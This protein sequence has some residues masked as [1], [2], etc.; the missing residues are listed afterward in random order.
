MTDEELGI[1]IRKIRNLK[2][3]SQE[4]L[5]T[6]LNMSQKNY[7]R[8]ESGQTS[9]TLKI[10]NQICNIFGIEID[11]LFK[12]SES[13]IFNTITHDQQGGEFNAYNNT[14]I[15]FVKDLYERLLIE[16]DL[17]IET[18]DQLIDQMK[19]SR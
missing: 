5:A 7:S 8:I 19:S 12:F 9:P 11:V 6:S 18:K 17:I 4:N 3:L 14:E 2:G 15:K 1:N 10:I 16:K 13:I